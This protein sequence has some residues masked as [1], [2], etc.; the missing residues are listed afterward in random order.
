MKKLTI[1]VILIT[2]LALQSSAQTDSIKNYSDPSRQMEYS[3]KGQLINKVAMPPDCGYLTFGTVAE[4]EI[5]W[6]SDF[7]YSR[8]TIGVIFLC[9]E[10]YYKNN[11]F[12]TGQL[13]KMVVTYSVLENTS[14]VVQNENILEKYGLKGKL[15]VSSA[16]KISYC[17]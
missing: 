9:P 4:F 11:F 3:L 13:Y 10:L 15:F 7:T 1:F 8:D 17:W 2:L 5:C 12:E 14:I 16:E 6:F